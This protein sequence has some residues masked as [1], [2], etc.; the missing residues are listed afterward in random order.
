MVKTIL[1]NILR[2]SKRRIFFNFL[3]M[4]LSV[5]KKTFYVTFFYS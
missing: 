4:P 3:K 2:T 1:R 5:F